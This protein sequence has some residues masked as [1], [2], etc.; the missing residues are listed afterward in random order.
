VYTCE[1]CLL[2]TE[3]CDVGMKEMLP[4]PTA[5]VKASDAR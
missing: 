1:D 4:I 5:I 2:C 3:H